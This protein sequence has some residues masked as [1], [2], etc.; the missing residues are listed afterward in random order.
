ML[1]FVA[2][3]VLLGAAAGGRL[4][5]LGGASFRWAPVALAGLAFQ[6]LLFSAPIADRVGSLGPAVYVASTV[7]V[8]AAL[9]RNLDQPGFRV[10][11]LG[12][13]ANLVA[14]V[15]NGGF[16][17]ASADA[18]AAVTGQPRIPAGL[19]NSVIAGPGAPFALLGD[20][21]ALPRPFPLANVFSIGDLL[22]GLGA[23]TFIVRAMRTTPAM[24]ATP[25]PA[26]SA[27]GR[28][29]R[30]RTAHGGMT[31]PIGADGS[32]APTTDR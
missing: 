1:Y 23:S 12:A 19:G 7:L 5:R 3:G 13:A 15:S 28:L 22:I 32:V 30:R 14:I 9:L 2:A 11:A 16:M 24:R 18:W 6:A 4:D 20:I 25:K 31:G 21:F 26:R 10:I 29:A 27:A 8:F 17:P